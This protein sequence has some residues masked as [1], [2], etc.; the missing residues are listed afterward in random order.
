MGNI[1][2][3][4][5]IANDLTVFTVEGKLSADEVQKSISEFYDGVVTLNV[6][7]DLSGCD[8]SGIQSSEIQDIA[9]VPRKDAGLSRPGG[10][11]A[12]VATA[13]IMFGLSRMYEL[14]TQ[15]TNPEFETRSFRTIAEAH[16]WLG[17][18]K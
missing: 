4:I 12:I 7:W 15:I 11:T 13:D 10:K 1:N 6:L 3:H 16:R 8:A 2:K 5:D 17:P 18:D 14:L 9:Q